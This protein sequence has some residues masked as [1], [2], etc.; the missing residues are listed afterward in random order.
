MRLFI[1]IICVYRTFEQNYNFFSEN[2]KKFLQNQFFGT[3]LEIPL[4]QKN[5]I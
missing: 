5:E 1:L 4:V 3:V 2:L